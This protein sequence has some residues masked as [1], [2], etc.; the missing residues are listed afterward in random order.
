MGTYSNTL[1][2]GNFTSSN[3]WKLMTNGKDKKSPGKPFYDYIQY[4]KWERK[5]R[6]PLENDRTARTLSWGLL[7][8]KRVFKL[9]GGKYVLT[10]DQSIMHESI[11]CWCG[12]PDGIKKPDTVIDVKCPYTLKSFAEQ[13]DILTVEELKEN[14]E[15]YYWQL[16]S[17]SILTGLPVCELIIYVPTVEE[18][19][20][21]RESASNYD[22]NQ[23]DVAWVNWAQDD[24]LPYLLPESEYDSIQILRWDADEED[25]QKLTERVL[26][27]RELLIKK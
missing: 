25:K 13:S 7:N 27:A 8:E 24:E 15:E 1:R 16:I 9:L 12:S 26:M 4:K 18:L 20:A 10:S 19:P 3:I 11:D 23:N 6:R 14:K 22:W 21:I 17:N 5:L 2:H